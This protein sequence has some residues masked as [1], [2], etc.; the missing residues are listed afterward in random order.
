[1]TDGKQ[2]D[3]PGVSAGVPGSPL[4]HP[5]HTLPYH[6]VIKELETRIDEGLSNEEA[7]RRLQEYGPNKLEEGEGVSIIKILVRQVANAMMLVKG[8]TFLFS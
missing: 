2:R 3:S 4:S 6:V 1:M 8:P 5:A 7:Q